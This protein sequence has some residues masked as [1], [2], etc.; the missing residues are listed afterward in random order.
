MSYEVDETAGDQSSIDVVNP[1]GVLTFQAGQ[2][3]ATLDL[4]VRGDT[5]PELDEIVTIRLV[6]AVGVS[7]FL[8]HY[9]N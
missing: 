9:T 5:L 2:D 1:S 7:S 4:Q 8:S 3:A 6:Q